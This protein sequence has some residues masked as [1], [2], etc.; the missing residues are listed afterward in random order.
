MRGA[1]AAGTRPAKTSISVPR[2]TPLYSVSTRTWVGPG[3]GSGA[4]RSSPRPGAVIQNAWLGSPTVSAALTGSPVEDRP[5][6]Q[7]SRHP[8]ARVRVHHAGL[9][10]PL[11][12]RKIG[13]G[14][15]V[16]ERAGEV[17]AA[18]IRPPLGACDLAAAVAE[19]RLERAKQPAGWIGG[20]GVGQ[21]VV[22]PPALGRGARLV[23]GAVGQ[24]DER[25]AAPAV[26]LD[27]GDGAAAKSTGHLALEPCPRAPVERAGV[28]AAV[29]VERAADR[30]LHV[31]D[32]NVVE[33][34]PDESP[35]HLDPAYLTVSPLV[36]SPQEAAVH[37]DESAVEIEEDDGQGH[38]SEE[39]SATGGACRG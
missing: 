35:R 9:S 25:V 27:G 21:V 33:R 34:R 29:M 5:A 31:D 30:G 4:G 16:E 17:G 11:E 32:R 15:A 36:P 38:P 1:T 2:L 8:Q 13:V 24:D 26:L 12:H 20:E 28:G 23:G 7:P 22:E 3:A 39:R 18:R 14:V 10:D 6:A 37:V 19:R